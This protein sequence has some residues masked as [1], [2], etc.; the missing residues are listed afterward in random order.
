MTNGTKPAKRLIRKYLKKPMNHYIKRH[1]DNINSVL[2]KNKSS[3]SHRSLNLHIYTTA[4][5]H[6]LTEAHF[7]MKYIKK[8]YWVVK[9]N[10]VDDKRHLKYYQDF[11]SINSRGKENHNYKGKL[12]ENYN[13]QNKIRRCQTYRKNT[14][15][16]LETLHLK[17]TKI[18][19]FKNYTVILPTR[20]RMTLKEIPI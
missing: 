6:R 1:N 8:K 2:V 3:K 15:M 17:T 12:I 19:K 16:E 13:T 9:S 4:K 10:H 11:I 7:V 5:A 18:F 20:K 14:S